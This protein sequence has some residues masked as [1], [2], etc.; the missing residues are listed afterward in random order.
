MLHIEEQAMV[1]DEAAADLM[2]SVAEHIK[3]RNYGL[4]RSADLYVRFLM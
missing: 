3:V 1:L 2:S 4:P